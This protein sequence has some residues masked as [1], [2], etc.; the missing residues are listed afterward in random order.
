MQWPE[1]GLGG[2]DTGAEGVGERQ[3]RAGGDPGL[4]TWTPVSGWWYL[5]W[6]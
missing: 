2:L 3:G 1:G 6:G 5:S 4:L